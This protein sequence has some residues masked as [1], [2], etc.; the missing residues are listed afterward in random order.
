MK[1][2]GAIV[3]IGIDLS[4]GNYSRAGY[5]ATTFFVMKGLGKFGNPLSIQEKGIYNL[6]LTPYDWLLGYGAETIPRNL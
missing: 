4:E 6:I 5:N 1:T 2:T 3:G